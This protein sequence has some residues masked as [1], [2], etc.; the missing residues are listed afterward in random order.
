MPGDMLGYPDILE[1]E[2]YVILCASGM[3]HCAAISYLD[4]SDNQQT[5]AW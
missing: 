4:M 5:C 3:R 2:K 1:R